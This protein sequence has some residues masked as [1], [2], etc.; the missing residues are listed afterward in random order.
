[1]SSDVDM[2]EIRKRRV[3]P[4]LCAVAAL[5]L[6]VGFLR[7]HSEKAVVR[8][9]ITGILRTNG[10][11]LVDAVVTNCG[12]VTVIWGGGDTPFSNVRWLS[13]DGWITSAVPNGFTSSLG[14][15]RPGKSFQHR[16]EAPASAR[17]IQALTH[18]EVFSLGDRLREDLT[19]GGIVN[20]RGVV[21]KFLE[22]LSQRRDD[23]D[24]ASDEITV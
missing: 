1:M 11:L 17:R 19:R 9:F 20:E 15:L 23:L 18:F 14:I 3:A 7:V 6:V 13:Q 21:A 22:E 10:V 12:A 2:P 5:A 4:T 16:F 24:V 8:V